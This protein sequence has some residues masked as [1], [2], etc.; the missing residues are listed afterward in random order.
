MLGQPGKKGKCSLNNLQIM[1]KH[2]TKA[3][4]SWG[5]LFKWSLALVYSNLNSSLTGTDAI[6]S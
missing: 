3:Q 6:T 5:Q 2:K 1:L 4:D